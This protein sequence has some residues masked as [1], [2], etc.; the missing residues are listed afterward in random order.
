MTP[1]EA[2]RFIERIARD[3]PDDDD[4]V[5]M[6]NE[7]PVWARPE[8]LAPEGDWRVW[9]LLAGRGFGKTRSGAEWVR[10]QVERHRARRIALV[11]PTARDARLVMVEGDSG[12]LNIEPA[13]RR[14]VFEPS[15]RQLTWPNGAVAN[16]FSADEP[17][18]L[19][20][21]QFDAA[22]CDELAACRSWEK[23]K[24]AAK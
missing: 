11:A 5:G 16:L 2:T 4:A 18:R 10:E 17:D 9:L 1:T 24:G 12:L 23:I 14:P 3:P 22:W 8:Q 7:W 13:E 19:R 15:K 20:G 6:L 21:P